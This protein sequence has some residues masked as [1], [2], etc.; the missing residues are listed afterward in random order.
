MTIAQLFLSFFVL[1]CPSRFRS[2]V[3]PFNC[4]VHCKN[5]LPICD[6]SEWV[7][8]LLWSWRDE[9]S[10]AADSPPTMHKRFSILYFRFRVD[11]TERNG[12]KGENI[13]Y[14]VDIWISQRYLHVQK[15]S[16]LISTSSDCVCCCCSA[17]SQLHL[18]KNNKK[19]VQNN[20]RVRF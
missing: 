13:V 7:S 9:S 14:L 4:R 8:L 6:A 5:M 18:N 11:N 20:E 2:V 10:S 19:K 17:D 15:I 3:Q 16:R 12:K 1:F